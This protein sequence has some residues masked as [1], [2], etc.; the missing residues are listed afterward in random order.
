MKTK[1]TA[2]W[3]VFDLGGVVI[4][5]NAEWFLAALPQAEQEQ[6]RMHGHE[7]MNLFRVYEADAGKGNESTLFNDMREILGSQISDQALASAI[8]AMLG[9]P[10]PEMYELIEECSERFQIACLSNTNHLHWPKILERYPVMKFFSPALASHELGLAKPN[11]AAFRKVE[12]IID[13]H[14][15]QITF[16]DDKQD[17]VNAALAAG[18]GAFLFVTPEQCRNQ[19]E[20]LCSSKIM[21][22]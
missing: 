17:N 2:H 4:E 16:F 21:G 18:W 5:A 1:S 14:P 11:L 15:E 6:A 12:E 7:L 13:A 22:R 10:I 8:D 19:I 3:L 20:R 9:Q